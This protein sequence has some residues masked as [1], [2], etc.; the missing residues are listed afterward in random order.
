MN[1]AISIPYLDLAE[2][3]KPLHKEFNNSL[4]KVLD[5]HRYILGKELKIFE[6]NFAS[7]CDSDYSIGVGNGLDA[8]TISLKALD[9]GPGDEVIVP[10]NTYIAT[11]LAISNVGAVIIPV[12]PR[13]DTFNINP[14]LIEK[15]ISSRTKAIIPV[16]LYGQPCEMDPI[17]FI[18]KKYNLFLIEDAAQAHFAKYRSKVVGGIGDLTAFSF[19]PGKNLGALGD[20]GAITTNNKILYEKICT[21]RNYGSNKKY[22]NKYLGFNSRLDEIQAAFLNSKIKFGIKEMDSRNQLSKIYYERLRKIKHIKLPK[23]LPEMKSAWHI[24]A[25]RIK[26]RNR[27]KNFLFKK[28]IETIIH[29]PIPP[30]L[31]QA[32]QFLGFKRG[33]FP[34][35][36]MIHDEVLSL[37]L[38]STLNQNKIN[39][40]CDSI[41][42]AFKSM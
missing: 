4:T 36:E 31:Q 30:H 26:N 22:F 39:F 5:S 18:A 2:I 34:I 41:D 15:K 1:K 9:I 6:E 40:I 25:I 14:K 37:P 38:N 16:H 12:E 11:W 24:F 8:L 20:G 35:S 17:K 19:Y 3:N 28:G 33:D 10:S 7:Q 29:Y 27:L 23:I 32:Y 13:E 42:E 21:L